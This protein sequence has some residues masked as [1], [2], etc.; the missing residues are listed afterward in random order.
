MNGQRIQPRRRQQENL[1]RLRQ[2]LFFLPP[3]EATVIKTVNRLHY[4]NAIQVI[5]EKE[6]LGL[7]SMH[8]GSFL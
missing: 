2:R 1:W 7:G 8:E 5:V 4:D 3:S 6:K